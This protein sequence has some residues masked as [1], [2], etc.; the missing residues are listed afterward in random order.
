[1]HT[2]EDNVTL[3]IMQL[4]DIYHYKKIMF[5]FLHFQLFFILF[6][7]GRRF[8]SFSMDCMILFGEEEE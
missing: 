7:C 8:G 3:L 6:D 2:N 4:Q 5:L 1:M